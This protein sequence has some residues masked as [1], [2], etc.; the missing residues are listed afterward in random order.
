[1][2]DFI[3]LLQRAFQNGEFY[4]TSGQLLLL[5]AI[6]ALLFVTARWLL[7]ILVTALNKYFV[8]PTRK[9]LQRRSISQE[10]KGRLE[11]RL[12]FTDYIESEIR[13]LNSLESWSH[14]RFTELEAEVEAEGDYRAND[15][16]FRKRSGLRRVHSLTEALESSDERLILLQ[17]EPGSGK[18]V[19]LRQVVLNMARKVMQNPEQNSQIP[20]YINMKH[21]VRHGHKQNKSDTFANPVSYIPTIFSQTAF[22]QLLQNHFSIDEIR[23]IC[24]QLKINYENLAGDTLVQK[25]RELILHTQRQGYLFELIHIVANLRPNIGEFR[26]LAAEFSRTQSESSSSTINQY[27]ITLVFPN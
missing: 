13:R 27:L 7:W 21:L 19:A 25:S 8:A 18:S 3:S 1:M 16:F 9:R 11:R 23:D 20:I 5:L 6:V 2:S 17:G 26:E 24:F 22:H 15:G 10:E 14:Y 4:L 12:Q